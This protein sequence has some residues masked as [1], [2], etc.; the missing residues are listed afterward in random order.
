MAGVS[1]D[2]STREPLTEKSGTGIAVVVSAPHDIRLTERTW[3]PPGPGEVRIV[4]AFAGVCGTDLEIIDG[5]MDP[6]YVR[7]PLVLGHE[8]SGTVAETGSGVTRVQPGDHVVVEG[9]VPDGTCPACRAGATNLCAQYDELGFTKDGAAGPSVTAAEHLVHRLSDSVA[10][11]TGALVEPMAVVIRGMNEL[12]PER[13]SRLLVIGDGTVGLLAAHAARLWSPSSIVVAGLRESQRQL[14][15][16]LGATEFTTGSIDPRSFDYVI[17][18]AGA[19][20]AV[21]TAFTAPRRGGQLLLLGIAGHER[22][23]SISS[24]DIVNN[25][26]RIRGSFGY[27]AEAWRLVVA[28]L[29]QGSLDPSPV[30]THRYPLTSIEHAISALRGHD[31]PS[32]E[33]RGKVLL[34]PGEVTA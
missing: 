3:T 27:T 17:E 2:E 4:P 25:D 10:L 21:E 20:S 5:A 16:R 32:G 26:L 15:L 6:A 18:A 34:V 12:P 11:E 7:Y 19:V 29:N 31:L 30:V 1:A 14:A 9:I 13:G 8:W 24:D 33:P 22:A 23:V 28:L